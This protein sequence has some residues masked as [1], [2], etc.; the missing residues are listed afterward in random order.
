MEKIIN[1]IAS[2]PKDKLLHFI[3]T[4]IICQITQSI[5]HNIWI[6]IGVTV[7]CIILKEIYDAIV[8]NHSVELKDILAGL[9]GLLLGLLLKLF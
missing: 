2:I 6:S 5:G 3:L 8:P 9:I 1:L 4:L 7:G